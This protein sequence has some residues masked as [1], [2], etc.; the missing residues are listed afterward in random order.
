ML[1]AYRVAGDRL[2]RLPPEADIVA[3]TW[4][5]LWRPQPE[6]EARVAA[7]GVTVPT[8]AD[9]EEIEIS[10]RLYREGG[11]DYMTVVLP[12]QTPD[13]AQVAGPV[14]FILT[15]ERLVTV[16]HHA[17]RPFE[18]FA[19]RADKS[20]AGC[21]TPAH[22]FLGLVEEII[23]RLADLLENIGRTLD[24]VTRDIFGTATGQQGASGP[25]QTALQAVGREG[26]TLGRIRLALLTLE[27]AVSYFAQGTDGSGKGDL[28]AHVKAQFRDIQALEVHAD[29]LS[30]RL[31]NVTDT[32]L[33]LVNLEQN[34]TVRILSVVAAL[35]LPPTLIGTVYGMNFDVMPELEWV[36]GYP[37]AVGLMVGS[38]LVTY[39]FLKWK[40]WL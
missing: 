13:K 34:R 12:G 8:L 16:R 30:A 20:T 22:L 35:F 2:E 29:F 14:T 23:G 38:A 6:Q 3:A 4:I 33:G 39:L 21:G 32:T 24:G 7:L 10:N 27:R 31:A 37:M 26:E 18:T 9:M 19:E 11:A 36:W 28:K 17:P 5:D 40:K 1:Y 25:L 15:P